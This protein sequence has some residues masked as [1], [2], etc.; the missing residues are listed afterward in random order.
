MN[1]LG[2]LGKNAGVCRSRMYLGWFK[3]MNHANTRCIEEMQAQ[4]H[5]QRGRNLIQRFKY[6]TT[7][8]Q[9]VEMAG[10]LLIRHKEPTGTSCADPPG[11][12]GRQYQFLSLS[13]QFGGR[14]RV[15][16]ILYSHRASARVVSVCR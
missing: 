4:L 9:V 11:N 2:N 5:N 16:A 3:S 1:Y 8:C 10:A 6:P 14:L 12:R 15:S 13:Y 7:L